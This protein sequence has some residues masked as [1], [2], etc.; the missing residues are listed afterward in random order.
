M[1]RCCDPAAGR[2][3]DIL[4]RP[5]APLSPPP[6]VA[7]NPW[8][9]HRFH[10][11]GHRRAARVRT[12]RAGRR[13]FPLPPHT[14][15]PFPPARTQAAPAPVPARRGSPFPAPPAAAPRAP[16]P[17]RARAVARRPG[18][19]VPG[20]RSALPATATFLRVFF[21]P[22]NLRHPLTACTLRARR[23]AAAGA[24]CAGVLLPPHPHT[25]ITHRTHTTPAAA[26][27]SRGGGR[28]PRA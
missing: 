10:Q 28:R 5:E 16:S 17:P 11:H 6:A 22:R 26:F 14:H 25:H 24:A 27:P 9:A 7:P 23:G 1:S 20:D 19:R 2:W 4:Q 13:T 12:A 21:L 18:Q 8:A 3:S 15:P